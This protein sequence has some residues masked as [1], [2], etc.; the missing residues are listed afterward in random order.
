MENWITCGIIASLA[1]GIYIVILKI[2]TSEGHYN[3]PASIAFL[4]MT[5]G[6]L[7]TSLGS[8]LWRGTAAN[9]LI[10]GVGIALGAGLLWGIGMICVTCGL[11]LPDTAVS[12]LVPLYNTNTLVAVLLGILFLKEAPE[13]GTMVVLLV[14]GALLVV[15]GGILVTRKAPSSRANIPAENA[16][17][18]CAKGCKKRPLKNCIFQ[19]GIPSPPGWGKAAEK[20][21]KDFFSRL[22]EIRVE[23]WIIYGAIAS[24]AWGIYA[25]LLKV[26]TSAEYYGMNP[27]SAFLGMSIGILI[28]S[29]GMFVKQ[30]GASKSFPRK[31]LVM[32]LL[33]G[34][35]WGI[36][37][38]FTIYALSHGA[39]IARL[40]PLYNTNTLI[41]TI[42]GIRLLHE[43]PHQKLTT[44][45]GALLVV[46]GGSL[47]A[48][49]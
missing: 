47:V 14:L 11:S 10:P 3:V 43:V 19:R 35:I 23:S 49:I 12:K 37:M 21:L 5:L 8:F 27:L 40:V 34:I 48:I 9:F 7:I 45:G 46:I 32:A 25:L 20:C 41:A 18:T 39:S 28:T 44:I 31:G 24:L 17:E 13:Q 33:A 36:G 30:R 1:W 4:F 6:I 26:A 16:A 2:A 42:L 38:V 15:A 29:V 22:K